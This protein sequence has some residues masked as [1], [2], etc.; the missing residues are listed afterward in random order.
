MS[1]SLN[2]VMLIGNLTKDAETKFT[3]SGKAVTNF[4]IATS[5]GFGDKKETT[6]TDVTLWDKEKVSQYL[7]KG[8]TVY[9]EGT[10]TN[11]SYED[12][13]GNKVY[14]TFVTGFEIK[15][16]GGKPQGQTQSASGGF[17]SGSEDDVPF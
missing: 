10:L 4:S 6:Y 9:V 8:T 1:A 12:K 14:K 16:L 2:K 13:N 7:V 5:Y 15:L 11:R 17:D 3:T